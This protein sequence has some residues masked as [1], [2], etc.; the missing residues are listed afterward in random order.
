MTEETNSGPFTKDE[1]I[2]YLGEKYDAKNDCYEWHGF[3]CIQGFYEM[4][5]GY[6]HHIWMDDPKCD[7]CL[8]YC[9]NEFGS[10]EDKRKFNLNVVWS[11]K[12]ELQYLIPTNKKERA[13]LIKIFRRIKKLGPE[14][15]LT[16]YSKSKKN[17]LSILK[18]KNLLLEK[19]NNN[20]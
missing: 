8:H 15:H 1:V 13:A 5:S 14:E 10:I 9:C 6:Y 4:S 2:E 11:G 18:M 7:Y 3:N 19:I 17:K 12:N 20:T 16:K